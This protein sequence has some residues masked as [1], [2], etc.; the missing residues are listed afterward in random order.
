MECTPACQNS[1]SYIYKSSH[2]G[3]EFEL[4]GL[5]KFFVMSP[6]KFA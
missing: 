4:G 5:V 1:M 6:T 2:G 3:G